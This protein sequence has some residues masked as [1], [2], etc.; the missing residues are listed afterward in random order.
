ML[1][2]GA[3]KRYRYAKMFVVFLYEL[4]NFWTIV[5]NSIGG[6]GKSVRIK[7]MVIVQTHLHF[8]IIT[9]AIYQIYFKKWLPAY[10]IKNDGLEIEEFVVFL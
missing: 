4:L 1:L 2:F 10:K 8:Q 9:D 7:P 3:I 6:N 5:I